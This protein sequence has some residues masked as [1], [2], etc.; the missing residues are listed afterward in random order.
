[1]TKKNIKSTQEAHCTPPE[2]M[3]THKNASIPLSLSNRW[4]FLPI[5]RSGSFVS[6][7]SGRDI[8][9]SATVTRAV[10][11]LQDLVPWFQVS[12]FAGFLSN[13]L[14]TQRRRLPCSKDKRWTPFQWR[15]KHHH[16]WWIFSWKNT[17]K[18]FV[19]S[20]DPRMI[21]EVLS[22]WSRRDPQR[23]STDCVVISQIKSPMISMLI[24]IYAFSFLRMPLRIWPVFL[25][26][27]DS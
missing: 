20:S 6:L 3:F 18:S 10:K 25:Q 12:P 17:W 23:T 11:K 15:K 9:Y 14:D 2:S 5:H 22:S 19:I 7:S 4:R 8:H 13:T 1:M 21:W 24:E 26:L 27:Y 16:K